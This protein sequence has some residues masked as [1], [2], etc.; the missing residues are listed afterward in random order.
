MVNSK[1]SGEQRKARPKSS[2]EINATSDATQS[3]ELS[4]AID[5]SAGAA[6]VTTGKKGESVRKGI[7]QDAHTLLKTASIATTSDLVLRT[8]ASSSSSS[9]SGNSRVDEGAQFINEAGS[10]DTKPTG[11]RKY[12][13]YRKMVTQNAGTFRGD[14]YHM[15]RLKPSVSADGKDQRARCRVCKKK[16]VHWCMTCGIPLCVGE[17]DK[18]WRDLNNREC[19]DWH[20]LHGLEDAD[21]EVDVDADDSLV[22]TGLASAPVR[23]QALPQALPLVETLLPVKPIGTGAASG[24]DGEK[25]KR[26]A[27]NKH[28][29]SAEGAL[30]EDALVVKGYMK[31]QTSNTAFSGSSN[32]GVSNVNAAANDEDTF[33]DSTAI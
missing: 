12:T 13:R 5:S 26:G 27:K 3:L 19:F 23:L 31:R 14:R 30:E 24:G 6:N 20:H 25:D 21:V 1:T 17:Y 2:S 4:A 28:K 10:P 15:P 29:R 9:S 16:T 32:S 11:K 33:D 22:D 18:D 7:K 8:S